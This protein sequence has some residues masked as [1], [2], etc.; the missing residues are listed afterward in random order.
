MNRAIEWFATNTVAANLIMVLVIVGG[1]VSIVGLPLGKINIDSAIRQEVFPEFSLDLLTITVP[2]LGASPEE[3]EEAVCVRIEEA[4]LGVDGVKRVTSNAA[5]GMGVATVELMLGEDIRRVLDDVRSRIDAIDTFPAETERPVIRE[6]TNRREVIDIAVSGPA[7][8]RALRHLADRVRDDLARLPEIT[9]TEVSTSREFEISIEVSEADLRRHGL[10]LGFVADAV[11]RSSLDLP[12]GQ[13]KTEGGEIL[14][15]TSGQAETGVQFESLVL[16]A[17]PDGT[18]LLLG[19]VATVRDG[20]A[21]T[22]QWARFNGHPAQIVQVFRVG[23]QD[24]LSIA[25]AVENYIERVEPTLP[26]G[27][28]LTTWNDASRILRGRRDLLARNGMTG[29]ALVF[30]NLALFLR[31]RLSFWVGIGLVI[32][33]LGAFWMMPMLDVSINLISLFAFILVLG[34]VVDDAIVVAENIHSHQ[35]RHGD[36]LRG[37][38]EGAQEM[39]IPVTFAVLTTVAAF[40]PLLSVPGSTGKVMAVIPLIVIPCLLWSLVESLWVLPAH[41]AHGDR[42]LTESHGWLATHWNRVQQGVAGGLR[43]FIA[44]VYQPALDFALEWRYLTLAV[45]LA[46]LILTGAMIK[47]GTV[48]FI[49][50]PN[51]ES[52]IIAASIT[53]PPGTP[54]QQTSEAVRTLEEAA[55]RLRTEV[56]AETGQDPFVN[57]VAVVGE[58]PFSRAQAQ[59]GGGFAAREISANLG[60]LTIEL[61]PSEERSIGSEDLANR[62][63]EM[64]GRIPDAI[65]TSFTSSLFSPGDDVNVQLTGPDLDELRLVADQLKTELGNFAGVYQISDSFRDG[66]RQIDLDIKPRAEILG[67]TRSDLARQVRQAFYGEEAQRIQRGRDDVRVMVRF[68]EDERRSLANLENMRVRTPSGDEIPF[69]TVAAVRDGRGYASVRRVDRRRAINVTAD[70]DAAQATPGKIIEQVQRELLPG[71]LR[72]HPAVGYTFEG[73]QSEQRETLGGLM[74][75]FVVALIVIFALLAVPLRSYLQ[76]VL[77]MVAIPF[78]LVGAVWGHVVLGMPLTILSMFGLVALTGVVVNDSLVLVHHINRQRETAST[79]FDAVRNSGAS[80]FR[81][82]LLTSMTTFF[83]LVPLMLE[84]SMQARFLIPMAVSVAFGVV[85][86]TLITLGLVPSCYLILEDIRGLFSSKRG[87]V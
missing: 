49:F 43:K 63:R 61:L 48:R 41:L 21:D 9:L 37:A 59:N 66:K 14:L 42:P 82:I 64:A 80:R 44:R 3:V 52:D 69:S 35:R 7:D 24:A 30:L 46:L 87:N 32:A 47:S 16:L 2:Y 4:I 12:G 58:H 13:V 85:F 22:D 77:I 75:G 53:L 50:F 60:E 65:Q 25:S 68:P 71:I 83:G 45:G 18:R 70:V 40:S 1:L 79:V 39:A 57:L 28:E 67:L 29:L 6:L 81:P 78:G 5:E 11:R 31:F 8:T 55:E 76:P 20:F 36:M 15:R 10:T 19:D 74:R 51:V 62:W 73:Q 86:A 84:R 34:I 72:D 38:I 27:I 26:E 23:D 33:F 17:R 54:A 56:V